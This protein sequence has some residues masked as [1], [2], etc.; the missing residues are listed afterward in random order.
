M[1]ELRNMCGGAR[2]TSCKYL[3]NI[4][5]LPSLVAGCDSHGVQLQGHSSLL[6]GEAQTGVLSLTYPSWQWKADHN[7]L[8]A[9]STFLTTA[10]ISTLHQDGVATTPFQRKELSHREVRFHG[11]GAVGS[12][13]ALPLSCDQLSVH[14]ARR[15]VFL[16]DQR[17][18]LTSMFMDP[19]CL[20]RSKCK[21]LSVVYKALH[22]ASL[23][24][25]PIPSSVCFRDQT[26]FA[27]FFPSS[28]APITQLPIPV[29]PFVP[30]LILRMGCLSS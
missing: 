29:P 5:I 23:V 30:V 6:G 4:S 7:E 17:T 22:P 27:P 8:I 19:Y 15:G 12:S 13:W 14:T 25:L 1:H 2:Q 28:L 18:P 24:F 26:T 9:M 10:R 11:R 16:K 3:T 20:L 21:F